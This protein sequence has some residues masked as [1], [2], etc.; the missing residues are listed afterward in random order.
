MLTILC[1]LD[2]FGSVRF[3]FG[4]CFFVRFDAVRRALF[5]RVVAR[6]GSVRFCVRFRPVPE[7]NGPVRFGFL[8]RPDLRAFLWSQEFPQAAAYLQAQ[9]KK[10]NSR[11]S[12]LAFRPRL[13]LPISSQ[14]QPLHL[15]LYTHTYTHTHTFIHTHIQTYIHTYIHPSIHTYTHTY[16]HTYIHTEH[17]GVGVG[18]TVDPSGTSP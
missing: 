15:L 4:K 18:A 12:G 5:E 6:F 13:P 8:F 10:L 3:V 17:L 9:A 1:N 11:Y 14:G 16:I 2:L 7:S